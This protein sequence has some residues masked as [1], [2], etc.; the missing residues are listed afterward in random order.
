MRQHL[1]GRY[2]PEFNVASNWLNAGRP[3]DGPRPGAI[4]VKAHH[5]FQVIRVVDRDHVLAISGND[6]NDVRTRIRPTSDVIG[7]RDVTEESTAADKPA[8]DT[9]ITDKTAADKIGSDKSAGDASTQGPYR[10]LWAQC[11]RP[12]QVRFV[13]GDRKR[14]GNGPAFANSVVWGQLNPTPE[15][16]KKQ[17]DSDRS[18]LT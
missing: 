8:A 16:Q 13:R 2:G 7:W 6:H 14:G 12:G 18:R 3:L 11:S 17:F 9:A 4:G 10:A 5:V 1:G 15:F